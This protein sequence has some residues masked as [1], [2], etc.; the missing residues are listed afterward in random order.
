MNALIRVTALALAALTVITVAARGEAAGPPGFSVRKRLGSFP[1]AVWL[2]DPRNAGRS[3][4]AGI[5][6]YVGLWKGP[7]EAQLAALKSAGMPVICHQNEVGLKSAN[8][9]IILAWM[10]GDEP[11]NAQAKPGG[12]Y[13][14]PILPARIV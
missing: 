6:V 11:D 13:G 1:I 8:R 7:T 2:Q 10:H 5:N 3:K 12:G 4:A 14:P 9:D